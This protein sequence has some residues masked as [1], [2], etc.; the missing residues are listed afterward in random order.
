MYLSDAASVCVQRPT[1]VTSQ[2]HLTQTIFI[3]N[4]PTGRCYIYILS[5][6]VL[7]LRKQNK[8]KLCALVSF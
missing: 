5:L 6:S 8:I 3:N 1:A 2:L 4:L 7:Q